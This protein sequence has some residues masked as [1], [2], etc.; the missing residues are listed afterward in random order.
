MA[1]MCGPNSGD[2]HESHQA[3]I[4]G[5]IVSRGSGQN[6]VLDSLPDHRGGQRSHLIQRVPIPDVVAPSEPVHVPTQVL[7][8]RR[9]TAWS[10][11][12]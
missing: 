11:L 9:H 6:L 3:R 7:V 5:R 2:L 12:I 1:S 8:E 4:E 10:G